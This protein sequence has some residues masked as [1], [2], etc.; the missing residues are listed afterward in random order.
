MAAASGSRK[1]FAGV[2]ILDF[3]RVLAGPFC[4]A[5]FA[6]LGADVVKVEPPDGDDQ[7]ALGAFKNGGSE[8]FRPGIPRRSPRCTRLSSAERALISATSMPR[9]LGR[10]VEP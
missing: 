6:D 4:T 5:I 3:T 7:R 10:T 8:N 1:T 2:R 9:L